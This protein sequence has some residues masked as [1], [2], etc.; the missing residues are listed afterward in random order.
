MA[1]THVWKDPDKPKTC[2]SLHHQLCQNK[3]QLG[4]NLESLISWFVFFAF[5]HTINHKSA[6]PGSRICNK[7]CYKLLRNL[8]HMEKDDERNIY[9]THKCQMA[10]A[11]RPCTADFACLH[12]LLAEANHDIHSSTINNFSSF[13]KLIHPK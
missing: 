8:T 11:C 13:A 1:P 12:L 2:L 7:L 9:T 4:V 5:G 10:A 3:C 6:F